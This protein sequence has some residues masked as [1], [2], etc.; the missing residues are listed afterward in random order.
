MKLRN[1]NVSTRLLAGFGLLTGLLL[2]VALIGFYGLWALNGKL[3]EI[4]ALHLP[5]VEATAQSLASLDRALV[6]ISG[7]PQSILPQLK[8]AGITDVTVLPP[9]E[10][11]GRGPHCPSSTSPFRQGYR[12]WSTD[13]SWSA[14]SP[15]GR[16][17]PKAG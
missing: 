2:A 14:F 9:A 11:G 6:V 1:L 17:W 5:A 4:V 15:C 8:A 16:R 12:I 10:L 7:D 13:S 3:D